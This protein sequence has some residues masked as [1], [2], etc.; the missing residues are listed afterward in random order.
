M[1]VIAGTC[2]TV[3]DGRLCPQRLGSHTCPHPGDRGPGCHV[4]AWGSERPGR[5]ARVLLPAARLPALETWSSERLLSPSCHPF[6]LPAACCVLP[7]RC[8]LL[9]TLQ[10]FVR[11]SCPVCPQ[12]PS[13]GSPAR[14][15]TVAV[16]ADR[17]HGDRCPSRQAVSWGRPRHGATALRLSGCFTPPAFRP[18]VQPS[19]PEMR[20]PPSRWPPPPPDL[21]L[22]P[23]S[24]A[25]LPWS[26]KPA[27]GAPA[28]AWLPP[29][30][31]GC[32]PSPWPLR[33]SPFL[34]LLS[35][36][37]ALPPACKSAD[38]SQ[39]AL[40]LI[41]FPPWSL[42]APALKCFLRARLLFSPLPRSLLC[43]GLRLPFPTCPGLP[44]TWPL[45]RCTR[46]P[47]LPP[48]RVLRGRD[49]Y[50]CVVDPK[51]VCP[52]RPFPWRFDLRIFLRL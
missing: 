25:A 8:G 13:P 6:L 40:C 9:R 31:G 19:L 30:R 21:A 43:A 42:I 39:S 12:G 24:P 48:V 2:V 4:C 47:F 20:A 38:P 1:R 11:P 18:S 17:G 52:A 49:N 33:P 34:P 5:P 36:R 51:P 26:V 27:P 22:G 23:P 7:G 46:R 50:F 10:H 32:W 44:H 35:P 3:T 29:S 16:A 28:S 45:A 37:L 41:F 14:V 15:R